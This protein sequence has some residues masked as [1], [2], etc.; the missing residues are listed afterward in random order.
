MHFRMEGMFHLTRRTAEFHAAA[1][2]CDGVY[3]EALRLQLAGHGIEIRLR[4]PD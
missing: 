3:R 4:E 2:G 1:S